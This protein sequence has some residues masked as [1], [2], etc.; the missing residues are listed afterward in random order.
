[1]TDADQRPRAIAVLKDKGGSYLFRGDYYDALRAEWMAG[2][3]C[4][5]RVFA[6]D[7]GRMSRDVLEQGG[8]IAAAERERA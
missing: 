6:D 1:M 8:A 4:G 3:L 5:L 2:K 7:Q